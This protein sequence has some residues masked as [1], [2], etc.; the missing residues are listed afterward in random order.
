MLNRYKYTVDFSDVEHFIEIHEVLKRDLDFPDYYGGNTDALWDCM[1]DML[2]DDIQIDI[3]GFENI[4][5][6]Y[7]NEW[8][9]II[10]I[11]KKIKHAY[12]DKYSDSFFVT[13]IY[14]NEMSED[15]R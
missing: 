4:K 11:F 6:K 5:R 1:T 12:G 7:S 2:G 9:K 15:I 8:N 3:I 13:L 10:Q 14:E